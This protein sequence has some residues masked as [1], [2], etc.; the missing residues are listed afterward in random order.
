MAS[1]QLLDAAKARKRVAQPHPS[2][3]CLHHIRATLQRI[4]STTADSER[5]DATPP[6]DHG[7]WTSSQL[8][9]TAA[10]TDKLMH[11]IALS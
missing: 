7:V 3:L 1:L 5:D 8:C 10:W 4:M 11:A 2:S 6:L 9:E